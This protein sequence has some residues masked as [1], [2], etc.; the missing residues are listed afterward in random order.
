MSYCL[1]YTTCADFAAAELIAQRLVEAKL[2]AC[3]NIFPAMTSIYRWQGKI[4]REQET[5]VLIKTK[6]AL[7]T[8]VEEKI[9]SLHSYDTCCVIQLPLT[10]GADKFL[11]WI[12]AQ[13]TI[14]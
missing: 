14:P 10:A 7:F 6:T 8:A 13:V 9:T 1:V 4:A 11:R 12:E 3:V 2:A 5:A